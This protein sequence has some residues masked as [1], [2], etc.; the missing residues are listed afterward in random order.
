MNT[1]RT[2][3]Q[4]G[5]KSNSGTISQSY[6]TTVAKSFPEKPSASQAPPN[7]AFQEG[8]VHEFQGSV[9]LAEEEEERH[10]HRF[11]GVSSEAIPLGDSHVHGVFTNTDFFEEHHHQIAAV[12][13][14]A[15]EIGNGKHIHFANFVTSL[16]DGH[17]HEFQFASLIQDPLS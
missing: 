5:S 11:A 12:S 13:G 15:I 7:G 4:V 10:N 3:T 6:S 8:H 16:N 2:T 14:P 17:F 9:K 1:N